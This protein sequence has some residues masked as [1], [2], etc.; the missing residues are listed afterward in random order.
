VVVH[1]DN[2][3]GLAAELAREMADRAWRL[4]KQFWVSERVAPADAIRQANEAEAGLIIMSDTGDSVYG[5]APGDG[6]CILQALLDH[7][8]SGLAYVPLVDREALEAAIAAG[9]GASVALSVGA[10]LDHIFNRPARVT[11]EVASVSQGF[12]LNLYD[13]GVCDLRRTALLV[14]GNIRLALLDHRSFA[15][16]HPVLYTHLG[17]DMADAKVVIVKTASNFQFF[18]RWRRDLIRIDSPGTTQSD[19]TAFRWSR[20]PRPTYP[21]DPLDNW[22]AS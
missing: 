22:H 11:G 8:P 1:T 4:R 16:N 21:L 7:P 14:I 12:E 3:P 9:V 15:I 2:D 19:L 13:R 18:S 5:G 20:L 10:R 6:T 17:L